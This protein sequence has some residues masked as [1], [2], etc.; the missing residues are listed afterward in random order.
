VLLP[1]LG[2]NAA[3]VALVGQN[4]GAGKPERV[5]ESVRVALTSGMVSMSLGAVLV[6]LARSP[7]F[8]MFTTDPSVRALGTVYLGLAVLAF[9]AYALVVLG[10]GALQGLRRPLPALLIGVGRHVVAPPAVL[11]FLDVGLG[12]GF[13]GLALGVPLVSWIGAIVTAAF[14]WRYLPRSATSGTGEA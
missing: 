9:P 11:W 2:L 1:T 10:A 4:L 6:F 3:T 12:L 14:L 13:R 5:R 8:A 7:L